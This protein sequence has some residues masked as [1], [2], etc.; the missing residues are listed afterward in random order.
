[1]LGSN[2]ISIPSRDAAEIT[3]MAGD[4]E[5]SEAGSLPP[6]VQQGDKRMRGFVMRLVIE[7]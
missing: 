6:H 3:P 2:T 1:M 4:I 7:G 5:N